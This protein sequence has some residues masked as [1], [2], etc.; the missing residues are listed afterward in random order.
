MSVRPGRSAGGE[1]CGAL[2][3]L[4]AA[5]L[6]TVST[7]ASAIRPPA[8]GAPDC[9]ANTP[10]TW[11]QLV[12]TAH[13]FF[14]TATATLTL[15]LVPTAEAA[16][17]LRRPPKGGEG[18]KPSRPCVALVTLESRVPIGAD[19]RATAWID[20]TNGAIEQVDKRTFGGDP[21]RKVF[22]Y[23]SDGFFVWRSSPTDRAEAGEDP[24]HWSHRKDRLVTA[25]DL[26]KGSVLTDPYALLYLVSTMPLDRP[27]SRTTATMFADDRLARVTFTTDSLTRRRVHVEEEWPGGKR[28][29]TG[30]LLVRTVKVAA[31]L[32]DANEGGSVDLG[33]LGIKGDLTIYVE[34]DT[35]VPV[36]LTGRADKIGWLRVTLKR[37]VL[38]ATPVQEGGKP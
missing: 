13:K 3:L 16:A 34:R 32:L 1:R 28:S 7:P 19:E 5:V 35:H 14:L 4:V 8:S 11:R 24:S 10:V 36:E 31:A 6:L 23:V 20:P 15:D 26:P 22:R 25:P 38:A 27:G 18:V 12:F 17:G 21:Y 9:S 37:A 33:F 2:C 29:R 30:D